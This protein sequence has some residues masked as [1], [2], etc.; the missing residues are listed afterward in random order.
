MLKRHTDR[1]NTLHL[2]DLNYMQYTFYWECMQCL[3]VEICINIQQK[4]NT[5]RQTE[6]NLNLKGEN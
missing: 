5:D 4:K 1:Q 6:H 2:T 3:T